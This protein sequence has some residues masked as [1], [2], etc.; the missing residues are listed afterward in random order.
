MPDIIIPFVS[1]AEVGLHAQ[2]AAHQKMNRQSGA[3][4]RPL[5]ELLLDKKLTFSKDVLE[6][7]ALDVGYKSFAE[8]QPGAEKSAAMGL[9]G[10][11]ASLAIRNLPESMSDLK[12]GSSMEAEVRGANGPHHRSVSVYYR[13]HTETIKSAIKTYRKPADVFSLPD[14]MRDEA[15]I[16]DQLGFVEISSPERE[17]FHV[18]LDGA[19]HGPF[20][21]IQIVPSDLVLPMASYFP[22]S[23]KATGE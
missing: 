12:Y 20:E 2:V 21:K 3:P 14:V 10:Q 5:E 7:P 4:P 17:G 1:S 13:E 11:F 9:Q 23:N 18:L 22:I 16:L 19:V 6:Q 8:S 15:R